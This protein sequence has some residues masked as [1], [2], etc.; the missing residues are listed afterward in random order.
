M[1]DYKQKGTRIVVVLLYTDVYPVVKLAADSVCL[2]TQCA[3][4]NNV[5]RQPK[6]YHTALLVKMNYKMGGVNHTLASRLPRGVNTAE[7]ADT[8]QYPPKSISWLF[9]EPCMVIG[10]SIGNPDKGQ[11]L[12]YPLL[13]L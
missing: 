6:N 5:R 10:I 13:V 2:P 8:F 9:D 11:F 12:V 7:E 4:W 3:K 1:R